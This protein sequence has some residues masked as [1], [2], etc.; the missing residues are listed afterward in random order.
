MARKTLLNESELRRFMKLAS[1]R[2][3]G[4]GRLDE[5]GYDMPAARD[6]E[7]NMEMDVALAG[8]EAEVG[9]E[10]AE[11]GDEEMELGDEEMGLEDEDE[12]RMVSVDDFMSALEDALEDALGEPT[13]VDMDDEEEEALEG[14]EEDLDSAA[15]DLE[16]ADLEMGAV[17]D[18]EEMVAEIARRV[19]A[20][21]AKKKQES[22]LVDNLTEKI[23]QRLTTK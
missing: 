20:R 10:D 7:D 22:T 9:I 2:P 18:E 16:D 21:L 13:S 6:E 19:G 1:L 15:D 14:G 11:L 8:D 23:L 4:T 12:G 3:L 5:M 17:A